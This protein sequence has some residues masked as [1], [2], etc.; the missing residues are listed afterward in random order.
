MMLFF[1]NF[2]VMSEGKYQG[3]FSHSDLNY[4][5]YQ[6]SSKGLIIL[7]GRALKSSTLRVEIVKS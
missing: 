5:D 7:R 2:T 4:L 1:F 6:T 3:Y